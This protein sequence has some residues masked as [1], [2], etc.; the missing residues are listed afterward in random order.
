MHQGAKITK[1]LFALVCIY[2]ICM[3][4]QHA[5]YFW[6]E[7]GNLNQ[8]GFKMYIFRFSNIFPMAN[9]AL[10]PIAYGTL[11]KE[12]AMV[13][14][15]LLRRKWKLDFKICCRKNGDAEKVQDIEDNGQTNIAMKEL[16]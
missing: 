11:N 5:V 12:F 4:P 7:Y 14:K 16:L 1:M 2:A 9:C 15:G 6:M 8:M 10:N 3:L 13:F